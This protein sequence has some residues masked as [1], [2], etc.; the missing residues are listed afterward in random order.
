MIRITILCF[1]ILL[2]SFGSSHAEYKQLNIQPITQKTAVWCWAAVSEMVLKYYRFP[3][4]NPV[5][6]YQCGIVGSTGPVCSSN[7][8]ACIKP[9]GS[10][11]SLS[12]VLM[13]YQHLTDNVRGEHSGI[14]FAVEV[15][16]RLSP[17]AIA[18]SIEDGRPIMAGISPSGMGLY[19]PPGM[20]EHVALIIGYERTSSAFY[21]LVNDPMPYAY[22][23]FDPYLVAGAQSSIPAQYR[24]DYRAFVN[25]LLYKDSLFFN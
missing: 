8:L 11:F 10:A 5:G 20:S 2:F 19:Y 1:L 7:C 14:H 22:L 21:V 24:I 12:A 25:R 6:D 13:N 17:E 18:D 9:I 4:L 16:G 15:G 23:G 3:N